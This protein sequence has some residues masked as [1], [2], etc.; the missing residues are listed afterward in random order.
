LKHAVAV[1][2]V[3]LA[4][5]N[6]G[7]GGA[8]STATAPPTPGVESETTPS[9][10]VIAALVQQIR[11][12]DGLEEQWAAALHALNQTRPAWLCVTPEATGEEQNRVYGSFEDGYDLDVGP[13]APLTDGFQK[14]LGLDDADSWVFV[15]GMLIGSDAGFLLVAVNGRPVPAAEIGFVQRTEAFDG[16]DYRCVV[17]VDNDEEANER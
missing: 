2:A 1:I 12:D 10:A 6:G 11:T 8:D 17:P 9:S 13:N 14:A 16:H 3:L 7:S 5:C 15:P 4:A